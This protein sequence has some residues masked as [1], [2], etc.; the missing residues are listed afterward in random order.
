MDLTQKIPVEI[1]ESDVGVVRAKGK[2]GKR[3]EDA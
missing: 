3:G 2:V 1:T